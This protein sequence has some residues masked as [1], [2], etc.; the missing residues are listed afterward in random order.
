MK[1]IAILGSTGSIGRQTIEVAQAYPERLQ[2]VALGAGRNTTL[3]AKQLSQVNPLIY[4]SLEPIDYPLPEANRG[5]M[6]ASSLE[7]LATYPDVD[8]VVVA[9]VGRAGLLPTLAAL[10]AGKAVA[11]A[12][13]EVLVMAGNMVIET[14]KRSGAQVLPVDSEHNALWQCLRGE[15]F[16]DGCSAEVSRLI[17]TASGGAF[18]DYPVE[19]LAEVTPEEALRH[20]TWQMGDKITV[21]SAT[22]MNKGLEVIEARWLFDIPIGK[23]DVML[24]RESI[25][26]SMVEFVDGSVKAL[27]SCPDMRIPLKYALS[28]PE[29]WEDQ[30]VPMLDTATAG[31]LG[32]GPLATG[33]YPCFELAMQAAKMEGTYPA[34]LVGADEAAVGL[35]LRG[36]IPFTDI[37]L[38]IEKA[39]QNHNGQ[40][41]PELEDILA[42]ERSA[43]EYVERLVNG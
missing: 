7:D 27:L 24:H 33:R 29:R 43:Y 13:K 25:V 5:S 26:H 20:P 16:N 23:I 1:R 15:T 8:L 4:F 14:A 28:Y 35:F 31:R 12:N 41:Q 18:R 40:D 22:L 17:I 32:F 3:L 11:I 38:F 21:D 37:P 10:R 2:I 36:R 9:T 39:L 19:Q 42:A 30:E 34:A 6:R